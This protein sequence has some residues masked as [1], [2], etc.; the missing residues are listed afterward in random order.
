LFI[1]PILKPTLIPPSQWSSLLVLVLL[2]LLHT[3]GRTRFGLL[4]SGSICPGGDPDV[5][6]VC[7]S[8]GQALVF[9]PASAS[10]AFDGRLEHEGRPAV[11]EKWIARIW[12]HEGRVKPPYGLPDTY[13]DEVDSD[14]EM[15]CW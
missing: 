3:G 2:L 11:A 8:K 6:E 13:D 7:P 5:L 1:T 9:F 15:R 12:R 10:G 4:G 14:C